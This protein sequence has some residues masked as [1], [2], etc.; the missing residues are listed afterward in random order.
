MG[1]D[2]IA[3]ILIRR[4]NQNFNRVNGR[5]DTEKTASTPGKEGGPVEGRPCP[6][7]D[8][9]MSSLQNWERYISA[10][11]AALLCGVL[12]SSPKLRQD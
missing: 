9:G 12:F 5:E 1:P 8:P 4:G 6:H 10:V 11:E 3:G 7:L 2:A